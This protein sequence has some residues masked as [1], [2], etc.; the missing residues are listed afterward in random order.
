MV[1]GSPHARLAV[2]CRPIE[3]GADG[4]VHSATKYL[5]GHSDVRDGAA[6]FA[7]V[8][9]RDR[10]W[11]RTVEL[12]A[13]ADPFVAWLTLRGLPSLPLRMRQHCAGAHL[14]AGRLAEQ[15]Q[16]TAV[17]CL[18]AGHPSYDPPRPTNSGE[19]GGRAGRPGRRE[20]V[21]AYSIS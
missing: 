10:V 2:L 5:A 21:S 7:D 18:A 19:L 3:H 20:S 9:L 12:G 8:E 4:V 17:Y 16:V 14:L 6:V 1:S 13:R 15:E 11:P